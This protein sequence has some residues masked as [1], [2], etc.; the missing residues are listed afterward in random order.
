MLDSARSASACRWTSGSAMPFGH[1]PTQRS[2]VPRDGGIA[3][4]SANKFPIRQRGGSL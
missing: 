1:K 2:R 4:H 3:P